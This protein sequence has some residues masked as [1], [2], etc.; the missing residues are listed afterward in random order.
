[1]FGGGRFDSRFN[2]ETMPYQ[3][4]FQGANIQV[5]YP[6]AT[7]SHDDLPLHYEVQDELNVVPNG[8][9]ML[10]ES[11]NLNDGVK[12]FPSL[13][14]ANP[15]QHDDDTQINMSDETGTI[16]LDKN[17]EL[18]NPKFIANI[19]LA[20]FRRS[21]NEPSSFASDNRSDEKQNDDI[22]THANDEF[23]DIPIQ[24]VGEE[25]VSS[26]KNEDEVMKT[27]N[28]NNIAY[29]YSNFIPN[30]EPAPQAN[31]FGKMSWIVFQTLQVLSPS[32]ERNFG[33]HKLAPMS[34][35]FHPTVLRGTQPDLVLHQ[36][37]AFALQL[38]HSP[39]MNALFSPSTVPI[40]P[41]SPV[42]PSKY[43][44]Q[45]YLPPG[46]SQS[47][48]N[49]PSLRRTVVQI[50]SQH[51]N[52]QMVDH[53]KRLQNAP[54][55]EIEQ[56]VYD[57]MQ[58]NSH[59]FN[60]F[61]QQNMQF[62]SPNVARVFDRGSQQ[63]NQ[64]FGNQFQSAQNAFNRNSESLNK[65]FNHQL[66]VPQFPNYP[67][68]AS[69]F[70]G[71]H[72]NNF[73]GSPFVQRPAQIF[74][75]NT[76]QTVPVPY[77]SPNLRPLNSESDDIDVRMDKASDTNQQARA[78][79][80]PS[81]TGVIQIG[82]GHINVETQM[83]DEDVPAKTAVELKEKESNKSNDST[84]ENQEEKKFA[85]EAINSNPTE[86]THSAE[87]PENNEKEPTINSAPS[88]K[89]VI[90]DQKKD[91]KNNGQETTTTENLETTTEGLETTTLTLDENAE[92]TVQPVITTTDIPDTTLQDETTTESST[93][94]TTTGEFDFGER[95][96]PN[97]IRSLAG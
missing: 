19:V 62:P 92:S 54:P 48:L 16:R 8:G 61:M 28:S 95:L 51:D 79:E 7:G 65:Y 9:M 36:L 84:R 30:Y 17:I 24:D 74:N 12:N 83:S 81:G 1:M 20:P 82:D 3:P 55:S 85:E 13:Y 6:R 44:A 4:N 2:L 63:M 67:T 57:S 11:G 42:W 88:N 39:I 53:I 32:D 73:I 78:D 69:Q 94:E 91:N 34:F 52:P 60:N 75:G 90:M 70:Q 68:F 49:N 80:F 93:Q 71:M 40:P 37:K 46:L 25:E 38:D 26:L 41:T 64:F 87:G 18:V 29:S 47:L 31:Y 96:D 35:I 22:E 50:D 76:P 14:H 33:D 23:A 72:G 27:D 66:Q 10:D 43:E 77:I 59:A 21:S 58:R 56:N 5:N 89:L 97:V 15:P 86:A 45:K